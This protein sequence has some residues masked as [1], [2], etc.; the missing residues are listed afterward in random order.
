MN[1]MLKSI[2]ASMEEGEVDVI[3]EVPAEET[4]A[5]VEVIEVGSQ[6]ERAQDAAEAVA[7]TTE[8]LEAFCATIDARLAAG[9]GYGLEEMRLFQLGVAATMNHIGAQ[10]NF[11]PSVEDAEIAATEAEAGDEQALI[12]V[13]QEAGEGIKATLTKMWE[14]IKR[15]VARVWEVITTFFA[16]LFGT[17]AGL[18]KRGEAL[19]KAKFTGKAKVKVG[20][21]LLR[22]GAGTKGIVDTLDA[23]TKLVEE[24]GKEAVVEGKMLEEKARKIAN[25]KAESS[26]D[27]SE[28]PKVKEINDFV[29]KKGKEEEIEVTQADV[30]TFGT[31]IVEIAT[32]LGGSKTIAAELKKNQENLLKE[33]KKT[34]DESGSTAVGKVADKIG[35]HWTMRAAKKNLAAPYSKACRVLTTL[36][37]QSVQVAH[38]AVSV[39]SKNKEESAAA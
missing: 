19:K 38:K 2:V 26:D 18:K 17:V 7:S 34:I 9:K 24:T 5:V 6:V 31:K 29:A 11:L 37:Y 1:D 22:E 12:Q 3:A 16:K 8:S 4:A 10:A 13:S 15:A 35:A 28:N 33:A 21:D 39:G 23:A 36:A 25:G 27:V 14:A 32:L 20:A 30:N